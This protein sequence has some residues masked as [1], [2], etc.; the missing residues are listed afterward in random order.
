MRITL[1]LI[2]ILLSLTSSAQKSDP[3]FR[4]FGKVSERD[5]QHSYLDDLGYDAVIFTTNNCASTM[6]FTSV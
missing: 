6:F 4:E 2:V 1:L 5:F 3:E